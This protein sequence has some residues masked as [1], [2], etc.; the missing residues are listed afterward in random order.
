M[1]LDQAA[2]LMGASTRRLLA[3]RREKG[4]A[5]VAHGR[6][7]RRAPDATPGAVA[8]GVVNWA[9]TKYSEGYHTRLT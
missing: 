7:G 1:A 5:A 3:A 8:Y 2:T 6:Q 4:A 9:A